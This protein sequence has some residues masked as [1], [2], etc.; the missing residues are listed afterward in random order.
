MRIVYY[1]E[2]LKFKFLI[3]KNSMYGIVE[4]WEFVMFCVVV[5]DF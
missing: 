1:L 5:V 3:I 2:I 4:L